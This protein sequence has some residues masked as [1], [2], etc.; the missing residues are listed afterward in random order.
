M[1]RMLCVI[2][3][4]KFVLILKHID[5]MKVL[6]CKHNLAYFLFFSVISLCFFCVIISY[7]FET[8]NTMEKILCE[9]SIWKGI[10][11]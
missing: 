5:L 7:F 8:K 6:Y 11:G 1:E 9:I 2:S 4:W 10:K 3:I